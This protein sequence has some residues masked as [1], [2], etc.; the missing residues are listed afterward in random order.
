VLR[1]TERTALQQLAR[2]ELP[3][4]YGLA[5]RLGGADPGD[6]VQETLLRACRSF[7]SLRDPQAGCRWLR[8]ILTNV[9]RDW[10]RRDGR[11]PDE[12]LVDEEEVFS[13]YRTLEE[14]DP[15]P[16]SDTLHV[17]FLGAF[18]E[19]DVQLVLDR[20]PPLYRAPL[21]LRYIEGFAPEEVADMLG[22]PKGT[23]LSHLHRGRQRFERELWGYAGESGMLDEGQE[24]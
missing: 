15:F 24:R 17:D 22:L 3:S 21:V 8:T 5:R 14:E 23:L 7:G 11:S 2:E 13:L 6:L 19:H 4:L 9:W 10:L 1:T 18:S 16:Y 20:L 12:V